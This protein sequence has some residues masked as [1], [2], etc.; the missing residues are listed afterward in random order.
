MILTAIFLLASYLLCNLYDFLWLLI[1]NMA[2]FS[3]IM[4][5][6]RAS[7]SSP[8]D[9]G[10]LS[11]FYYDN[12]DL[13]LLLNLL[14]DDHIFKSD[15]V[16]LSSSNFLYKKLCES[17]LLLAAVSVSRNLLKRNMRIRVMQGDPSGCTLPFC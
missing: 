10:G 14:W 12:R 13:K 4:S 7:V 8:D 17:R 2:K 1:P 5:A 11:R 16:S 15:H 9:I 3:K 6:Y